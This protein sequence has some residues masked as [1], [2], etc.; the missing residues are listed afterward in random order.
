MWKKKKRQVEKE[1]TEPD[2]R[3]IVPMVRIEKI[4]V[5]EP[6]SAAAKPRAKE[7]EKIPPDLLEKYT[8]N[9]AEDSLAVNEIISKNA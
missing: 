4:I 1:K 5:P 3:D 9:M 7:E 2:I 8:L 6:L